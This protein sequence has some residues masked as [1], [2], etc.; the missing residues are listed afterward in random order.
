MAAVK[1]T[2]V[3]LFAALDVLGTN[4]DPLRGSASRAR[5]S[6][7]FD[8][9]IASLRSARVHGVNEFQADWN[10][11]RRVLG[12]LAVGL[13]TLPALLAQ[14]HP[15]H[16][17][18]GEAAI[19]PR[20]GHLEVSL[21]VEAE[22]LRKALVD[23]AGA[24]PQWSD[25]ATERLAAAY[26]R[27]RFTVTTRR[28]PSKL[29]WAGWEPNGQRIWLHFEML[30]VGRVHGARIS[31]RLLTEIEPSHVSTIRISAGSFK[32]SLT[33][34]KKRSVRSVDATSNGRPRRTKQD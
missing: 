28:G 3:G 23:D 9:L 2:V 33:F 25:P 26:V 15:H 10:S 34:D 21:S 17:A 30:D 24:L 32:T 11:R 13:V 1:R 5:P 29:R 19:N 31:C 27:S 14:S 16:Y 6:S 8:L 18:R 22:A 7:H 12:I 4:P 20:T